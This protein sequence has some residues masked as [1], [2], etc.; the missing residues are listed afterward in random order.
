MKEFLYRNL[1]AVL[2]A[3]SLAIVVLAVAAAVLAVRLGSAEGEIAALRQDMDR[4]ESGTAVFASQITAFQRQ[5]A[6]LAPTVGSALDEAVAGLETFRTSTLD[7]EVPIDEV[8]QIDTEIVLDRTITVPINTEIPITEVI[9]T[10]ITVDGPLGVEIPIDVS[11]PVDVVVPVDLD[12]DFPISERVPVQAEVPVNLTVPI[13]VDIAGTEL[14]G[15]AESLQQ[16]LIGFK[17][18][19]EGLG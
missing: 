9:D 2:G 19:I 12:L 10:T 7:F 1:V 5:L 15:L 6:D 17:E 8:V 3:V 16:G 13:Q 14:A 11:V 4:V 18:V